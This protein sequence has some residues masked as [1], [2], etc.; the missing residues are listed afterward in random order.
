[1]TC[2]STI[3]RLR[4]VPQ[5]LEKTGLTIKL[6]KCLFC[7]ESV[8]FL[9]HVINSKGIMMDPDKLEAMVKYPEPRTL[10][11]C[12]TFIGMCSYY[13]RFIRDFAKIASPLTD[14]SRGPKKFIWE[15]TKQEAFEELKKALLSNAV[16]AR[17]NPTFEI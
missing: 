16:L 5:H 2:S 17:Y 4:R 14:L 6:K 11:Q 13:R 8:T 10:K 7:Q 1:M 15:E 3:Q 9:G 12:Q